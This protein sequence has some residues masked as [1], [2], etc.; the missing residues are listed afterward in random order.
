MQQRLL[1]IIGKGGVGRSSVATSL[2]AYFSQKKENVLV[3]QWSLTDSISPIFSQQL[4]SHKEK[5]IEFCFEPGKKTNFFK[6]MNFD[7]DTAIKEYFVDHLKMKLLYS[8]I[9]QNKHVQKLIHA[10]PGVSE[11][12][13]LG[14]LFWLVELAK[15]ECGVFY[16]RIIIDTP[17]T[18]HGVSL[19]GIAKAVAALGITGP[20]ANECERVTKLL[21][22][23]KKTATILVTLPEELPTEECI[24]SYPLIEK[25]IGHK[26]LYLIVNQ[27][28]NP[29][30][31]P[32]LLNIPSD[33]TAKDSWLNHLSQDFQSD[34]AKKELN[35]IVSSLVKRNLYERRLEK[36]ASE[37]NLNMISIPDFNLMQKEQSPLQII[38]LMTQYFSDGSLH[39]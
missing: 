31:Y 33:L 4:V 30:L 6:T 23:E 15:Q 38:K 35:L 7:P 20:L 37:R 27:S 24:E 16:D 8:V 18:G 25:K 12:F 2:A 3:V 21:S 14:R 26:P 17:A 22:D 36:F 29:S 9:I 28:I 13:F 1:F 5:P 39:E 34:I 11:L 32:E 10:A 19:F